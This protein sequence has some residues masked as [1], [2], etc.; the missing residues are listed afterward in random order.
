[1]RQIFGDPLP[2]VQLGMPLN[3][4]STALPRQDVLTSD[5]VRPQVPKSC[6]WTCAKHIKYASDANFL[7]QRSKTMNAALSKWRFILCLDLAQ[8]DVGLQLAG[9]D[10]A[11][12]LESVIGVK[13]PNTVLKRANSILMYYR[14][15]AVNGK[16]PFLPFSEE[17]VWSYILSLNSLTGSATRAQSFLQALRFA[18]Y[19][20]GFSSALACAQSR[21]VMG[22]AQLQYALKA[23]TKQARALSVIEVRRLHKISEDAANSCIDRCIASSLLMALYGRCRISDLNH[24]HEILHDSSGNT[25]FVEITTRYHKAARSAQQKA[26]LLPIVI[27]SVG[28]SDT[29][30]VLVWVRNRKEA[31]LPVAGLIDGAFLP[32]PAISDSIEW[33]QRPLTPSE[34]TN[35]LRGMLDCDDANLTSHSLKA[36]ALSW[37]AK[38]DLA[39]DARRILGRHASALQDADSCYSRDLSVGPV[40]ALARIISLIHQGVF[41]PI[42]LKGIL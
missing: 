19:V 42:F 40:T 30:W 2:A 4:G 28:L 11:L 22:Q 6:N 34:V 33:L 35:I 25:G 20:M 17:D 41:H 32:A 37:A 21:R 15:H 31:G 39:R 27:S 3:W 29:E 5:D 18:Y 1:M 7:A 10:D 26:L 13:S 38:S 24:V 16:F 14:W 36:T 8:S 23:P 12:V 9:D